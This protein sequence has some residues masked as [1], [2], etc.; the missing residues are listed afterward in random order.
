M[1]SEKQR[2]D[3]RRVVSAFVPRWGMAPMSVCTSFGGGIVLA[4]AGMI[5]HAKIKDSPMSDRRTIEQDAQIEVARSR[6]AKG[7]LENAVDRSPNLSATLSVAPQSIEVERTYASW[8]ASFGGE[9]RCRLTIRS[10]QPVVEF[11]FGEFGAQ[12]RW[13]AGSRGVYFTL[14]QLPS[15]RH[16]L[17]IA[18]KDVKR[19]CLAKPEYPAGTRGVDGRRRG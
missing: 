8:P 1:C 12:T 9:V 7:R 5:P 14:D 4:S 3:E 13:V 17:A 16:A 18:I 15:V 2:P 11:R 6:P 10:G 19:L